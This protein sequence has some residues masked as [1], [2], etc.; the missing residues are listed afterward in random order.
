MALSIGDS[1]GG[2]KVAYILVD[3]DPGYID[4]GEQRGL[5]AATANQSSGIQW[6]TDAYQDTA[7]PAPG[8]TGEVLGTGLSNTNAIIAQAGAGNTY[9]A[10]L[11][12]AYDG[13]GY[14]DWFLPSKDELSKLY[15]SKVAVGGF[16]SEWYSSST[17]DT[18]G[19]AYVVHFY[20]G[21]VGNYNKSGNLYVR[22]VRY[23]PSGLFT[24]S[25]PANLKSYNG[26]AKASMKSIMGLGIADIKSING[27]A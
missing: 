16:Q 20:N 24:P 14:D 17:E 23:F 22:C 10:G 18:S 5:I 25:G 26:L 7:V 21:N 27:L 15:S 11:A 8:A 19:L 2:G 3:G 4:D 9:A 1:Y 13:G 6:T 12:R